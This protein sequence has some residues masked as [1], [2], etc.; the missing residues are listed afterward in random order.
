MARKHASEENSDEAK[1]II[2][3]SYAGEGK[4][5]EIKGALAG[6]KDAQGKGFDYYRAVIAGEHDNAIAILKTDGGDEGILEAMMYEADKLDAA[7][8]HDEAKDIWR[9]TIK[10]SNTS[11]R[12]LAIASSN[13]MEED[14]LSRAYAQVGPVTE[15][16]QIDRRRQKKQIK[17]VVRLHLFD[18]LMS[19]GRPRLQP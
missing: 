1:L 13:L 7:G 15:Q 16:Q 17:E 19:P 14:A 2:L 4:W 8:K 9:Q 10:G 3:E 11:D 6:W 18:N 12:V 5:D